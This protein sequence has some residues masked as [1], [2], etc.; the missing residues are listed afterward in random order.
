[1]RTEALDA[2][3]EAREILEAVGETCPV[4][5][6][7]EKSEY[8]LTQEQIQKIAKALYLADCELEEHDN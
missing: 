3:A 2:V 1:M 6:G 7:F 8:T 4:Y 5:V